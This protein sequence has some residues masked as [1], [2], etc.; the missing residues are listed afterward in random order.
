MKLDAEGP[1]RRAGLRSGDVI[2]AMNAE[3]VRSVDDLHR[4]LT[5]WRPGEPVRVSLLRGK[6]LSEIEIRLVEA[7]G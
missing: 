7:T 1:V 4:L 5:G 6:A 3:P 2:V